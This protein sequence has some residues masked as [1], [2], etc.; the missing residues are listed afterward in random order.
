M[1]FGDVRSSSIDSEYNSAC[2]AGSA[3]RDK[4]VARMGA[5][6]GH[7]AR[8]VRIERNDSPPSG[9]DETD[10]PD[11]FDE[12]AEPAAASETADEYTDDENE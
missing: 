4:I 11:E 3:R 10:A 9:H 1:F 8:Y 6:E 2:G 7:F 5:I 12:S